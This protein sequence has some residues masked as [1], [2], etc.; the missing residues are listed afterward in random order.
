MKEVVSGSEL[1]EEYA[2]DVDRESA[3]EMLGAKIEESQSE[4]KQ[5]EYK[6]TQEKAAKKKPSK[7]AA[8]EE[9]GSVIG[10]VL[11]SRTGQTVVRQ[12]T[13][14]LLGALGIKTTRRRSR[15]KNPFGF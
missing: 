2:E 4:A 15:K 5:E 11:N 8:K 14:G 7:K 6:K 1:V 12:V 9:E 13:R 3:Y 10:D